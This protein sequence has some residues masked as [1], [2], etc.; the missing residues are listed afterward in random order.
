M[1]KVTGYLLFLLCA[2][3]VNANDHCKNGGTLTSR[4]TCKCRMLWYDRLC[5]IYHTQMQSWWYCSRNGYQSEVHTTVNGTKMCICDK[6]YEGDR[7]QYPT[8]ENGTLD[9]NTTS[10]S[11]ARGFKGEQCHLRDCGHGEW[12]GNSEKCQCHK[13]WEGEYCKIPNCIHGILKNDSEGVSG[14]QCE[15]WWKGPLCNEFLCK[16]GNV[17]NDK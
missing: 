5:H 2:I 9:K 3:V 6:G 15:K 16:E 8:C 4:G 14:C 12:Y 11:C 17:Q 7:C 10:C 1:S 13:H